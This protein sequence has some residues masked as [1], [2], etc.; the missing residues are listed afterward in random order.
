VVVPPLPAADDAIPTAAIN[1]VALV[2]ALQ[3]DAGMPALLDT[4][5]ENALVA[6]DEAQTTF[7]AAELPTLVGRLGLNGARAEP[8]ALVGPGFFDWSPTYSGRTGFTA[9][10]LT[11]VLGTGIAS[12]DQDR[13]RNSVSRSESYDNVTGGIRERTVVETKLT[14][15]RGGGRLTGEVELITTTRATDATTAA[16][17]GTLT[18]TARGRIEANGCPDAD[19]IALGRISLTWQ[20]ELSQTGAV[21]AGALAYIEAP[22]R[23]VNG[24][25][26]HL[27]ETQIDLTF[28]RGAHG[29]GTPGSDPGAPFD[30]RATGSMGVVIPAGSGAAT[31][32]NVRL[33]RNGASDVQAG[34]AAS[35]A[36]THAALMALEIGA[37]AE[38]FWRSGKC[39]ELK[40]SQESREVQPGEQVAISV[41]A[42]HRFDGGHV[43]GGIA[44][45]FSGSRSIEPVNTPVDAPAEFQFVAGDL[46]GDKATIDFTQ[47]SRRGIGTTSLE[48]TVDVALIVALDGVWSPSQLLNAR[49]T[50]FPTE[51]QEQADGSYSAEGTAAVSGTAGF[52]VCSQEFID[53]L[54]LRVTVQLDPADRSLARVRV[55][56]TSGTGLISVSVACGGFGGT[57][58][59]P[60]GLWVGSFVD[61][62]GQGAV[63]TIDQPTTVTGAGGSVGSS[64]VVT[65]TSVTVP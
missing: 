18:A 44:A 48:F 8:I 64:T 10:L 3:R 50:F 49:I 56:L 42:T 61:A 43:A 62:S 37:E 6:V 33:E 55:E 58:P 26:A 59:V 1:D 51:L 15:E 40:S 16:A 63:V 29:P 57:V 36:V 28:A 14:L 46:R 12:A 34:E 13:P 52:A 2:H 21:S 9:S 27:V 22:V 47:T 31:T 17:R 41:D 23:F 39:I 4:D 32:S 25:D 20:E 11:A 38:R 19:G 60:L 24:D 35:T 7:A 53:S 5:G 45:T 54:P 65:L 30:W